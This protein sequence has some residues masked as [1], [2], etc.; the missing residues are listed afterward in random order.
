MTT[1]QH[2]GLFF[3]SEHVQN[4][5]KHRNAEPFRTAWDYL[6]N[7][8]SPPGTLA[9]LQWNGLRYR[10]GE[11]VGAG[12]EAVISLQNGVRLDIESGG[13]LFEAFATTITLA[14][15]FEMVRSH[16]ALSSEAQAI[17]LGRFSSQV[18]LLNRTSGNLSLA[19]RL[20]LGLLNVTAGIVLEVDQK[21]DAG[22]DVY[23]RVIH[24]DVRPEGYLPRA[25]EGNDGGSLRRQLLSVAALVLMAEAAGHVGVD[26]W[27][28]TSRGVS[29]LTAAAYLIY[30]YYYPDQW[31][32]DTLTEAEST[33][34]FKEHG[35]FLEMLN[36]HEHPKDIKLLLDNLRP[37]YS[38]STGGLTTLSHGLAARRGLFG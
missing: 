23:R 4:A 20:W 15:C 11:H 9:R 1:F 5:R 18:E 37:F 12:E 30:Y 8:D 28:Y 38:L 7:N 2:F 29:V 13:E 10:F 36:Y 14:Q 31:R 24:D 6:Q 22:A 19:D 32:W 25:V 34:V 16:P 3:T 21:F 26:L 35:A 17:W 33:P 27:N